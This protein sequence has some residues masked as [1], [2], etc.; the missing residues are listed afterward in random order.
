MRCNKIVNAKKLSSCL[1]SEA[2]CRKR[3]G[4]EIA[5]SLFRLI[6]LLSEVIDIRQLFCL[7]GHFHRLKH[8]PEDNIYAVKLKHPFS[9]V[10]RLDNAAS[11]ITLE[12]ICDYHGHIEKLFRK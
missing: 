12:D 9:C 5:A 4:K 11:T 10:M 2:A 3:F 7:P 8:L 1:V 6:R